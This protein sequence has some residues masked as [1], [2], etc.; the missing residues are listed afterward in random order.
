MSWFHKDSGGKV[1]PILKEV[2]H[3]TILGAEVTDGKLSKLCY[4]GHDGGTPVVQAIVPGGN[5]LWRAQLSR[6]DDVREG[7]VA[8]RLGVVVTRVENGKT[9]ELVGHDLWTGAERW[10]HPVGW[11]VSRL[12]IEG[13]TTLVFVTIDHVVHAIDIATGEDH[14]RKPVMTEQAVS[15]LIGKTLHPVQDFVRG[16][17][18]KGSEDWSVVYQVHDDL[19]VFER[20]WAGRQELGI[21]RLGDVHMVGFGS[22]QGSQQVDNISV[23]SFR[24]A[25]DGVGEKH[26]HWYLYATKPATL[27]AV[28][29]EDGQSV[30]YDHG[31]QVWTGKL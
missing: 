2:E 7:H 25:V 14:P 29:R 17:S 5:L 8:S 11:M 10:R 21:G 19:A 16:R 12:G 3:C 22:Y 24:L 13:G 31:H 18:G 15:D 4:T 28:L 26:H 23:M 6:E 20:D 1:H 9:H 27:L 30:L